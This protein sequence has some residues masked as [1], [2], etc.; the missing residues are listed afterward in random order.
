MHPFSV[1]CAQVQRE[2]ALT[3]LRWTAATGGGGLVAEQV[4]EGLARGNILKLAAGGCVCC[5]RHG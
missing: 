4:A 1:Q 2:L 5:Q 3:W